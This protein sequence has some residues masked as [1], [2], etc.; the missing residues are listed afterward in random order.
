[1]I[2]TFGIDELPKKTSH[3]GCLVV[4]DNI[5]K[6]YNVAEEWRESDCVTCQC[7]GQGQTRC[8]KETCS[9]SLSCLKPVKS[10]GN[11]CLTCL[12]SGQFIVNLWWLYFLYIF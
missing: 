2:P 6:A 4:Q 12:N 8:T 9:L 1:M 11:C 3:P 10:P 5:T 7:V